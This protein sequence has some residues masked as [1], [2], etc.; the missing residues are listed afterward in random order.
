MLTSLTLQAQDYVPLY[1]DSVPN[2]KPGPDRETSVTNGFMRVSKVSNP[3]M[4]I[5][6]PPA[7]VATGEAVVIFP[8][9]GYS[10]LAI[11]H[12]GHDVAKLLSASGIAA[13]VVKYRLPDDSI[14]I[15]RKFGPVQDAQRAIQMVRENATRW[16][17]QRDRIGI[18]GFS[19]GGHLASTAGTHFEK[20]YISNP[21]KTSLRPD[22][23]I[24][25]YPVIS[26]QD[27]IGHSGSKAN[28][29][30]KNPDA[31]TVQLFSNEMNV[32]AKTPRTY[33]IHAKDDKTVPYRNSTIFEEQLKKNKVP[34]KLYLYEAGGHGFGL[35]NKTSDV[36]WL[37]DV[38]RWV[39]LPS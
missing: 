4:T 32:T 2:S 1:V 37:D 6:L 31:K 20:E 13:F 22:F 30:G 9:G 3:G 8:G 25:V 5:Y 7:D 17:I 34:V 19:A 16:N 29:I 33:L 35:N 11:E 21:N 10:I 12:E 26:F 27:S 28:L 24:L 23:M 14:M 36:K 39:K 15:D 18:M 38:I